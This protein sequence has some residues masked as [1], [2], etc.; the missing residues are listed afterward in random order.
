T[1]LKAIRSGLVASAHD[2]SD[3]GL[4][5]TVA[6]MAIFSGV[7]C[8]V[9]IQEFASNSHHETLFSE[10]QSGV[11]VSVNPLNTVAF[12]AMMAE[13]AIPTHKLGYTGGDVVAIDD[14]ISAEVTALASVYNSSLPD[15]M[16]TVVV[17]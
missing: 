16:A 2:V 3:G 15:K 9:T 4:G 7:G 1:L 5:I 11:V 14:L 12:E 8:T 13:S 17:Q 10:A 6:E